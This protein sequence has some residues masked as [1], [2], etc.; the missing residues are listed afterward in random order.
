MCQPSPDR[1]RHPQKT[2]TAASAINR[3]TYS[4]EMASLQEVAAARGPH[5]G[6]TPRQVMILLVT[7]W[8][9]ILSLRYYLVI[10]YLDGKR[11]A[12]INA[13][14]LPYNIIVVVVVC[15]CFIPGTSQFLSL[16]CR[17]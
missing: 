13:A 8:R 6:L 12:L 3:A 5:V 1:D 7:R 17:A 4:L 16:D 10:S 9:P 14:I 2:T 15:A 11:I